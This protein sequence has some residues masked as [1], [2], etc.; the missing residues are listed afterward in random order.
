MPQ[1]NP[2]VVTFRTDAATARDIKDLAERDDRALSPF[3]HQT[4]RKVI[5]HERRFDLRRDDD[6][7]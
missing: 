4:L 5:A 1:K 2:I 7:K 3:I 6:K